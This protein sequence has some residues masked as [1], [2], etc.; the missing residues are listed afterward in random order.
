MTK[1][2]FAT[3]QLRR[4]VDAMKLFALL[5]LLL[6]LL[7]AAHAQFGAPDPNAPK[8]VRVELVSELTTVVPGQPFHVAL[9]MTHDPGWHSYWT[10]PGIGMPTK[11]AWDLP[12]GF[13][14]GPIISPIPKVKGGVAGNTHSFYD[15]IYHVYQVTPPAG[16]TA[17]T[18]TLQG[19][20]SWLQCEEDR[21]DPPRRAP[22]DVTMAVDSAPETNVEVKAEIDAV[23]AQ[24]PQSLEAWSVETSQTA[25]SYVFTLTPN[26]GA[27]TDPGAIYVFEEEQ[28][29][30]AATPTVSKE[31]DKIV[32]T[33]PKSS[34]DE[35]AEL[36]GYLYA[37]NGWLAAGGPKAML[38][39]AG[40]ATVDTAANE[41][42]VNGESSSP[43][44]VSLSGDVEKSL[45][46]WKALI[47]GFIGGMILNLMPCVFPVLSIKILGFVEQAG[48][49]AR[50]VKLH[51]LVFGLG[52]LV[53]CLALAVIIISLN[54]ATGQSKGWGSHMGYPPVAASVIIIMFVMGL[55]LA[56]LFEMGTSLVGAGGGLMQK[57]GMSGSFFSGVLT[58]IVATP[59]SGPF[60]GAVMSYTFSQPIHIALLLFTFFALGVAGP[61]MFLSFFPK[62][63]DKLPAPGAWME[64]F[65]QVMAFP[66]FAAAI[67]FMGGFAKK[68]GAS[69]VVWLLS[70]LLLIALGLWIYGKWCSPMRSKGTRMRAVVL[71]VVFALLGGYVAYSATNYRAVVG[72]D[73]IT[74]A[75]Q[76]SERI[77]DLRSEGK[78]VHVDFTASW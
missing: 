52:V 4:S 11:M 78:M 36:K 40:A 51:G 42:V 48:E 34:E 67:F 30:Q 53:S 43:D 49:D 63:V 46:L 19:T 17:E 7:T 2:P 60:L 62:L 39:A 5:G 75:Q 76:L 38:W 50:K 73:A 72:G 21:C 35:I 74:N 27:S 57:K 32:V 58:T 45:S 37:P 33:S 10:N 18:L 31:G 26:D 55:N 14:V 13:E 15:V 25:E 65:K 71:A 59:C 9:K 69:G 47:L 56:G 28:L 70:G 16:L 77:R 66:M 61:Y 68:T 22:V 64:T 8:P 24:Q 6:S 3:Y 23:L 29:L 12:E 54:A 1:K 44:V 41:G 20:A